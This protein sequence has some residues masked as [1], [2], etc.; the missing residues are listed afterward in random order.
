MT[1]AERRILT[2]M[3]IEGVCKLLKGRVSYSSTLD[4]LGN[5]SKKITITYDEK[6]EKSSS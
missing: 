5:S 4:Y 1:D 6:N 3:Q 2:Q